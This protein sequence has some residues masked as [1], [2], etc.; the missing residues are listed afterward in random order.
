MACCQIFLLHLI[1]IHIPQI[2]F[3]AYIVKNIIIMV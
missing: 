3:K 2:F 1:N